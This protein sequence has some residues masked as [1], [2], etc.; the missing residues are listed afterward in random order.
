MDYSK[1]HELMLGLSTAF[2]DGSNNS[3][4]AYRPEFVYNDCKQGNQNHRLSRWFVLA[5]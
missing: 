3:N 5:L 1:S 4:L 2:V